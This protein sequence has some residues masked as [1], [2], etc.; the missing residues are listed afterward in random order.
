MKVGLHTADKFLCAKFPISRA[1][2][3]VSASGA[4][5]IYSQ[6]GFQSSKHPVRDKAWDYDECGP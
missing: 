2:Y 5:V 4:I 3:I 1:E 6:K